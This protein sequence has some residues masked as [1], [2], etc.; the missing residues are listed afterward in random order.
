MAILLKL[1][2]MTGMSIEQ[3]EYGLHYKLQ[4]EEEAAE[5]IIGCRK[6]LKSWIDDLAQEEL[7]LLHPIV[8]YLRNQS[9]AKKM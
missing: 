8:A 2:E 5:D 7:N 3:L 9:L 6:E 1:S 4:D